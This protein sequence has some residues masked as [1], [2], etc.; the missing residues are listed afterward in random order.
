LKVWQETYPVF[1]SS[2]AEKRLGVALSAALNAA[3]RLEKAGIARE[4]TKQKRNP[5][6]V[7]HEIMD[8]L[9]AENDS[10]ESSD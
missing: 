4:I 9:L 5:I 3:I 6:W 10:E 8:I 7:A 2:Q 1:N